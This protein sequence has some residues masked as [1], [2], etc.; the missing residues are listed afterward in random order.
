MANTG[1]VVS[2]LPFEI[3]GLPLQIHYE[4]EPGRPSCWAHPREPDRFRITTV[5]LQLPEGERVDLTDTIQG[6]GGMG[7]LED[8]VWADFSK[9]C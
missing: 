8:L 5:Y 7:R 3:G 2:W 6:V 1:A 9:S 4:Y